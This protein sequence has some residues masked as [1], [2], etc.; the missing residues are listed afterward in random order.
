MY[1]QPFPWGACLLAVASL[2][3]L[4]SGWKP[5]TWGHRRREAK[6]R[7][8]A[9]P[10]LIDWQ[11]L[12]SHMMRMVERL[13]TFDVTG[14]KADRDLATGQRNAFVPAAPAPIANDN[15][16]RSV[17]NVTYVET[18]NVGSPKKPPT[19]GEFQPVHFVDT[20][21][22]TFEEFKGQDHITL[23]L[24]AKLRAAKPGQVSFNP[25]L[26]LGPPGLGK[27]TLAKIFTNEIRIQNMERGIAA[28]SDFVQIMGAQLD[29]EEALDAV[30][31]RAA[32]TAGS[33][34]FIDEIH[35]LRGPFVTKLYPLLTDERQYLFA[36]EANPTRLE[37]ITFIGATT[38]AGQ[39]HPAL[40]RRF[41]Q[42]SFMS[43]KP[44][45]LLDIVRTRGRPIATDAAAKI[46]ELTQW[47][48]APW[49][50]LLRLQQAREFADAR[51]STSGV[52]LEDVQ[53]VV[54]V[55]GLDN[56]GLSRLHRK[57]LSAMHQRPRYKNGR[58]GHGKE[59]VCFGDSEEVICQLAGVDRAL[60]RTQLKHHLIMR[61]LISTRAG[62]GQTL[63]GRGI[64]HIG[65]MEE[66]V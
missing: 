56:L 14:I 66:S 6:L 44:D 37:H 55:H 1:D 64:E 52:E 63:T 4:V 27:T 49:E 28:E 2:C 36:G 43:M 47:A 5:W 57:V 54:D 19:I 53:T 50:P 18:A 38:D 10:A 8:S 3:Y 22:S 59:F 65:G 16:M 61:G 34:I 45:A 31:R 9:P 33:V 17:T 7:Y 40:L 48:G 23:P 46:V 12:P 35:E 42:F 24:Q 13:D 30:V 29:G 58:P 26:F 11:L 25:I 41:E 62:Y 32:S 60:Y 20:E 21:P 15:D 51:G 39:L